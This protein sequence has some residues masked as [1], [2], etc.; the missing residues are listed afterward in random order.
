VPYASDQGWVAAEE[1][2][3]NGH[4]MFPLITG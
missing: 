1:V 3:L 4:P 2:D